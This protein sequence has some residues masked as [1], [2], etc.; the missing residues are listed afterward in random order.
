MY[1]YV[2]LQDEVPCC[3]T[4]DEETAVSVFNQ[5]VSSGKCRYTAMLSVS[6]KSED[7]KVLLESAQ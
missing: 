5:K 4:L 7:G 6:A 2:V 1:V 3:A